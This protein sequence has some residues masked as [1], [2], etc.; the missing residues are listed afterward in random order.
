MRKPLDGAATAT[1]ISLC[2]IWGAQQVALKSIATD[3]HPT[4]QIVIRSVVAGGLVWLVARMFLRERWLPDVWHRSGFI[5]AMFFA[6]G[7]FFATQGLRWTSASHMIVFTYTSP[8][9]AAI[10]LHL[11][12]PEERMSAGQ[13]GGMLLA[14]SGLAITFLSPREG[15]ASIDPV[16]GLL[17]DF[18]GVCAGACWGSATVAVRTSRMSEAPASQV[19]F[20]QMVGAVILLGPI[21]WV[22][23]N[24]TLT[25]TPLV[26]ASL[27]FQTLIVSFASYLVWFWMLRRY[28]AARMGG[29]S[30][31]TP[32]F[33]V[34]LG[35]ML[36]GEQTSF[37]FLLGAAATVVGL[38]L[39]NRRGIRVIPVSQSGSNPSDSRAP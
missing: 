22:T 37:R 16:R 11:R 34:L 12:L 24:A 21:A 4:M 36:L 7:W 6:V 32:L 23:G 20:Y 26:V 27:S 15:D 30:L 19:L 10:G 14:F 38:V 28:L 3:V 25:L 8:L 35:A 2:L 31:L 29:M 39:I 5:V 13:W 17:G 9:F 33:G 1:M 18:L